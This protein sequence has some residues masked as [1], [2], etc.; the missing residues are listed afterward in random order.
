MTDS[1]PYL[2]DVPPTYMGNLMK[3]IPLCREFNSQNPTHMDTPTIPIPIA[4]TCTNNMLCTPR[5]L[6]FL[7]L[8]LRLEE[9]MGS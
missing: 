6:R 9:G 3:M 7:S 8:R 2:S 1:K 4:Y 5:A